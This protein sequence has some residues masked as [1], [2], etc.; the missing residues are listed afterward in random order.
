MLKCEQIIKIYSQ[1]TTQI[2]RFSE[3]ISIE[4]SIDSIT[5]LCT[6][7]IPQPRADYEIYLEVGDQVEVFLGYSDYG[8]KLEFSGYIAEITKGFKLI[9]KCENEA[10]LYKQ[11]TIEPKIFKKTTLKNL[12]TYYY[13]EPVSLS[14]GEIGDWKVGP[15]ATFI[16]LLDELKTTF[17]F[18]IYW[19][20]GILHIAEA[21]KDKTT[22]N[23]II[24]GNDSN[25]LIGTDNVELK[26]DSNVKN[27]VHGIAPQKSGSQ[28]ECYVYFKGTQ[29]NEITVS[30]KTESGVLHEVKINDID[31][32]TLIEFCKTKLLAIEKNIASGD[33]ETFGYP[34]VDID[35]YCKI[36]SIVNKDINGV[37]EIKEIVKTASVDNGYT[38]KIG[39]GAKVG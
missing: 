10:W 15:N 18:Q 31:K 25:V 5:K 14:E 34:S 7:T 32:Q 36:N 17:G 30:E 20:N 19:I 33:V 37:Y 2:F 35:D 38:Q 16:N 29:K 27:V 26:S 9:L 1:K 4:N 3:S 12:I 24:Y 23:L 6:I 8:L 11:T 28:F 21:K 22:I 13:K 39:L